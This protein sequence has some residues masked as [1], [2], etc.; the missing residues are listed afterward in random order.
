MGAEPHTKNK[1]NSIQFG[2]QFGEQHLSSEQW[3]LF[4]R[5]VFSQS[6]KKGEGGE[7]EEKRIKKSIHGNVLK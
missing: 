7:E 6:G 4:S 1:K 3:P 5:R 2:E